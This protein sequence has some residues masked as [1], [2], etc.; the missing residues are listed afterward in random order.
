MGEPS[1]GLLSSLRPPEDRLDSWKEIAAYL[2]RDVTTAWKSLWETIPKLHDR[3]GSV[4]AFSWELDRA[5][6]I[7]RLEQEQIRT[8]RRAWLRSTEGRSG[9]DGPTFWRLAYSPYCRRLFVNRSLGETTSP[10]QSWPYSSEN[11]ALRSDLADGMTEAPHWTSL[12]NPQSARSSQ[13]GKALEGPETS[14]RSCTSSSP[15]DARS[16]GQYHWA[17]GPDG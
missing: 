7:S 11:W 16:K 2:S 12:Q 3:M 4:Y 1:P 14:C 6:R 5:S 10:E 9:T 8:Q 13:H 17:G 15:V